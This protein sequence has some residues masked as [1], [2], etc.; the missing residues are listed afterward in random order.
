MDAITRILKDLFTYG[1]E[2]FGFFYS[3]YRGFV[4][5]NQDP[6]NYNRLRV[7]VPELHGDNNLDV[8]AWPA[9]NY[10]GQGYGVQCI[11]QKG[12]MVWVKF[13]KGSPRKPIWQ[14]GHFGK[15]DNKPSDLKDTKKYWFRTPQGM[16]ILFNDNDKTCTIY[17]K[18]KDIEPMVL[19][20]T[21]EGKL[22]DLIE[23]LMNAK[24]NTMYGPQPFLPNTLIDLNELKFGLSDIKSTNNKLS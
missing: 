2:K 6:K 3:Q 15:D 4:A 20:T 5:D 13:E 1:M 12:D 19:G 24:V 7:T 8:W 18:D 9:S 16:T 22:D 17:E 23:I 21:L 11:P 14:Y 10:S